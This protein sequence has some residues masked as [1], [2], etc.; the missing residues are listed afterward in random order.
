M[1]N[2]VIE[3]REGVSMVSMYSEEET[4]DSEEQKSMEEIVADTESETETK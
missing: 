2:A 3:G 4:V 1:A